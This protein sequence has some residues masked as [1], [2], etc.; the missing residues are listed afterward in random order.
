MVKIWKS[1]QGLGSLESRLSDIVWHS[2]CLLAMTL[3]STQSRIGQR[4][5]SNFNVGCTASA[6]PGAQGAHRGITSW[7]G[8][9]CPTVTGYGPP[10]KGVTWRKAECCWGFPWRSCWKLRCSARATGL[11]SKWGSG[12]RFLLTHMLHHTFYRDTKVSGCTADADHVKC[13]W[14]QQ[15]VLRF[16]T[17]AVSS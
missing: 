3:W 16:S 4:E 5:R 15:A 11:S 17:V 10:L 2:G 14:C 12:M 1:Q 7:D 6:H 9:L 13:H 8:P